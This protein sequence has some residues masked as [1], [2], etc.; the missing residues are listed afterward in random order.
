MSARRRLPPDQR[1][2]LI[3]DSAARLFARHGYEGTRLDD[4]AA[5]AGVTKPILYRHFDSKNDLYLALLERHR[6]QSTVFPGLRADA[7]LPERARTI[8]D[9]WYAHFHEHPET[10]KMLFLDSGGDEEIRAARRE[11]QAGVHAIFA[12]FVAGE[13]AFGVPAEQ[14]DAVAEVLRSGMAGLARWWLEHPDVPRAVVTG[15]MVR[16][17]L[18]LANA[19]TSPA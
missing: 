16:V 7:P 13:P 2:S 14:V 18:G 12:G 4:I 9:A 3:E 6:N 19:S 1:R 11:I 10:W 15:A 5:D 17:V 8:V